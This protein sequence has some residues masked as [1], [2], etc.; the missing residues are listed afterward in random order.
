MLHI[1]L[2]LMLLVSTTGVTFSMHYCG[3]KYVS[4]SLFVEADSCCGDGCG[5]CE[6]KSVHYEVEEDYTG[7]VISA[8]E[9]A[10]ELDLLIEL[11]HFEIDAEELS[12]LSVKRTFEDISPPLPVAERLSLLQTFL[13]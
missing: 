1:V 11:F 6:N 8:L 3:G 7:P 10:I 13:C 2:S 12:I 4:T 9:P 5:C